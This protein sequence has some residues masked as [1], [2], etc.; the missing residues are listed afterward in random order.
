MQLC[1]SLSKRLFQ[2]SIHNFCCQR[3]DFYLNIRFETTKI[4][5][6]KS[7]SPNSAS[8]WSSGPDVCQL[9]IPFFFSNKE[10]MCAG[11][12]CFHL[13]VTYIMYYSFNFEMCTTDYSKN[14]YMQAKLNTY[15]GIDFLPTKYNILKLIG[16]SCAMYQAFL[17]LV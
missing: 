14:P 13:K 3:H 12:G 5:N 10:Q 17:T 6:I 7:Y 9:Q 8:F 2:H 4:Q 15:F 16:L 1:T 11:L